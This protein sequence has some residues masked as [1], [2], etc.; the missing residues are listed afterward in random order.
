MDISEKC[1]IFL[2]EVNYFSDLFFVNEA[3]I[4]HLLHFRDCARPRDGEVGK[5]DVVFLLLILRSGCWESQ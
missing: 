3:C 1:S 4:K 5:I 2:I